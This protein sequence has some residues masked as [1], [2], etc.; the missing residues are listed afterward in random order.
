MAPREDEARHTLALA[1]TVARRHYLHGESR[2]EIAQLLGLS[3]FKVARLL[4][5]AREEGI[6][7]IEIVEPDHGATRLAEQVR[8]R[9]GTR[10]CVVVPTHDAAPAAREEVGRAGAELLARLLSP[11]DVLGL[12]W[13]RSVHAMVN[14]L[15]T[16][17]AVPIVQLSGALAT[18]SEDSSSVDLVRRA[19]RIAQG[20]RHVFFAPLVMPD[21]EAAEAVRR[22]PA[23]RDTL[24]LASTVTVAMVGV[25][26]WLPGQSTI[27]D[28]VDEATRRSV[29]KAGVVGE[30]AG[31]FFDAEGRTV[32]VPLT[33]RIIAVSAEQL[34]AVPTV[35][36]SCHQVRRV[37]ALRAALAGGIVDALVVTLDVAEELVRG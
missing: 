5:L 14:G 23:V 32:R 4:E 28:V 18:D 33:R 19:A 20:G 2:V 22:D 1:A 3:R 36:A 31:V 27:F 29:E 16:L 26:A 13:S 6:V 9:W 21:A 10:E 7:R 15:T 8:A 11:D 37:P 17:P 30:T 34:L 24:A 35:V 25:G 12:P